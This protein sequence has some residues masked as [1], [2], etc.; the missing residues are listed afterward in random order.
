[1][2]TS[3]PRILRQVHLQVQAV[4]VGA[5][6][7]VFA[8]PVYSAGDCFVIPRISPG[9]SSSIYWESVRKSIPRVRVQPACTA[10]VMPGVYG[11]TYKKIRVQS[12]PAAPRNLNFC[13]SRRMFAETEHFPEPFFAVALSSHIYF[14]LARFS[15]RRH[16]YIIEAAVHRSSRYVTVEL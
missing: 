10:G 6:G 13:D 4:R 16:D 12:E 2:N 15:S 1:M 11:S 7:G 3:L 8:A 9:F 5:L 14:P